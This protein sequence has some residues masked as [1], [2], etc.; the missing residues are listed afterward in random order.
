MQITLSYPYSIYNL[1]QDWLSIEK[2]DI[3]PIEIDIY[4]PDFITQWNAK[5]MGKIEDGKLFYENPYWVKKYCCDITNTWA[6]VFTLIGILCNWSIII[7]RKER[8]KIISLLYEFHD[9]KEQ[10]DDLRI[11]SEQKLLKL[12]EIV[13]KN[14]KGYLKKEAIKRMAALQN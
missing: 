8:E 14:E 4:M 13:Q 11:R 12:K 1:S 9:K 3:P 7:D 2:T 10:Y 5:N 6:I